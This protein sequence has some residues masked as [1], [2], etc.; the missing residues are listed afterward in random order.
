LGVYPLLQDNSCNFVA[1]DFDDH[2]N[3]FGSSL[4]HDVNA[5]WEVCRI[6]EMPCYVLRSKSGS[7]YHVYSFFDGPVPAWKARAVFLRCCKKHKF[8]MKKKI[9]A[10]L[11][12]FFRTKTSCPG[13][14]LETLLLCLFREVPQKK[15]K[16]HFFWIQEQAL[17]SLSLISGR[18]WKMSRM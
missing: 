1:A 11:T 17:W 3:K 18:F 13:R 14:A 8:S 4:L 7:G 12:N 6:Q 10:G 15:G 5:F 9:L 16:T 2:N